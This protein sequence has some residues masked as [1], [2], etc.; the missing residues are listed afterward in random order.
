MF[1]MLLLE[2]YVTAGV[3]LGVGALILLAWHAK[4]PQEG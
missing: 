3:F 1:A 4:E 2:H